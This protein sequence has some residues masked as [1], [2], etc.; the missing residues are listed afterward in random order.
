MLNA[1]KLTR[2]IVRPP[3]SNFGNGLTTSTLGSP[4]H[5]RALQQHEA[6]CQALEQCGLALIRL[7]PDAHF[8]DSTFVEDTAV[9]VRDRADN[10]SAFAVLTRP[11]A[12]SRVGE[13][14]SIALTLQQLFSRI[15]LIQEPRTLDGGDVCESDD[16]FFIGV[17]ERTNEEGAQQLAQKVESLG[18]TSTLIDIRTKP[19]VLHLKSGLTYLGDNHLVVIDSLADHEAFHNYELIRVPPTEQ[20]AA[21]CLRVN[22]FVLVAAGNPK[23]AK[24]LSRLGY[25]TLP[26]EMTEFQKMEGGLS[27]LSL[28]W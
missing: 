22:D 13:V 5:V 17:S 10:R 7:E 16:H 15:E 25:E 26:L 12:P 24:E 27:C 11:G 18:Y 2:A 4:D 1:T 3:S 21:N 23:L 9:I 28:C 20:Y 14:E 19:E 6:Y 8:P